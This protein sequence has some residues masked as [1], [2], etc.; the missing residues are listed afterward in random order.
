MSLDA[1]RPQLLRDLRP[2]HGKEMRLDVGVALELVVRVADTLLQI[3]VRHLGEPLREDIDLAPQGGLGV[4]QTAR[5]NGFRHRVPPILVRVITV[6][7][8][9]GKRPH[10][11]HRSAL[12]S[13]QARPSLCPTAMSRD[14]DPRDRKRDRAVAPA[15]RS[16]NGIVPP[17]RCRSSALTQPSIN[18][19]GMPRLRRRRA[20][21]AGYTALLLAVSVL[22]PGVASAAP[23]QEAAL[24]LGDP[25]L[26]QTVTVE[27]VLPGVTLTT[28]VRGYAS[29]DAF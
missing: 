6:N 13:F 17:D 27:Q 1:A 12:P 26:P 4:D 18:V 7:G 14:E 5:T 24:P 11:R 16:S 8:S 15:A 10:T 23:G 2:G 19:S 29:A 20:A 21:L 28:Y 25:A 9:P 22:A 3:G